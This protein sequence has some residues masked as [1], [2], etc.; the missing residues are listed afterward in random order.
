MTDFAQFLISGL[1][2]GCIYG[3]IATGFTAIYNATHIVNFAQGESSMLAALCAA[4]LVAS[5][6]NLV[7]AIAVSVIGVAILNILVERTAIRRIGPD[8]T[9]GIIITI[10]VGIVLQGVAALVWGTDAQPLPA[11][12]GEGSLSLYGVVVPRQAIWVL[13]TTAVLMALLYVF[14]TRTFLGKAFR[15]CA[16]NRQAATLMGIPTNYMRGLGFLLSGTIGAVAGV[17]VAPIALMQYDSGVALG[18]KGFVACIIGG[19]GNPIGAALGGLLLGVVESLSA[20]YISSGFKNAIAFVLL[21]LFLLVR[22]G[23][24]LGEFGA[25]KR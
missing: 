21:L 22:P 7:T 18:I 6:A 2:V 23:G 1:V 5:G 4:G 13:G 17:I 11:F 9:R 15:A 16:M 24:I 19:F 20:G 3:L 8:V 12:S 10:G 14:L 25:S